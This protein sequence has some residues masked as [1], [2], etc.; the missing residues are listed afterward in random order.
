VNAVVEV[1]KHRVI[2]HLMGVVEMRIGSS[3]AQYFAVVAYVREDMY[4]QILMA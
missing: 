4:L 2:Y 1:H 3:F